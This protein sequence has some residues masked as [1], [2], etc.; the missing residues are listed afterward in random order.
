MYLE[1]IEK[2]EYTQYLFRFLCIQMALS[3]QLS[4]SV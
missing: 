4:L 3:G 2:I 1:K